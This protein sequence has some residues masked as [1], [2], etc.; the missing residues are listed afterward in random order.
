MATSQKAVDPPRLVAAG[1]G[2]HRTRCPSPPRRIGSGVLQKL[3]VRRVCGVVLAVVLVVVE[4][5]LHPCR[6]FFDGGDVDRAWR[7]IVEE[8]IRVRRASLNGF[9]LVERARISLTRL[10]ACRL[11][12]RVET[13]EAIN[14]P[15]GCGNFR[16]GNFAGENVVKQSEAFYSLLVTGAVQHRVGHAGR[17]QVLIASGVRLRLGHMWLDSGIVSTSP[18]R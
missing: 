3:Q 10:D 16:D 18:V 6:V 5:T 9:E 2:W 7:N 13:G 14:A 17:G 15:F 11:P 12:F 1:G 8:G 4:P